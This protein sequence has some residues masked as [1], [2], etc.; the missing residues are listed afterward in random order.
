MPFFNG[1]ILISQTFFHTLLSGFDFTT[2]EVFIFKNK[3]PAGR[4]RSRK[5]RSVKILI[6]AVLIILG[7]FNRYHRVSFDTIDL[8]FWLVVGSLILII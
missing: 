7:G 8:K 4:L 3:G 6:T 1:I 2:S 5:K